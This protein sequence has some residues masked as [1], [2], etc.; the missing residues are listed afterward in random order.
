MSTKKLSTSA[1]KS[2]HSKNFTVRKLILNIEGQDFEILVQEKFRFSLLQNIISDLIEAKKQLINID[3]AFDYGNYVIFLL[4]KY[5][6]DIS[7]TKTCDSFAKEI[8]MLNI[9]LDLEIV[10]PILACFDKEEVQKINGYIKKMSDNMK[11]F[12]SS[13]EAQKELADLFTEM[14]DYEETHEE[15]LEALEDNKNPESNEVTPE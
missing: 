14:Q 9:M 2:I 4:I 1:L 6:T 11:E 8:E 15:L 13:P 5:F 7:I 3:Q 12:S 10:E